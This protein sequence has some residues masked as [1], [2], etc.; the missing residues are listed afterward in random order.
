[1]SPLPHRASYWRTTALAL[2]AAGGC[3]TLIVGLSLAPGPLLV[4]VLIASLVAFPLLLA[5]L[6]GA[7][8]LVCL[9][10]DAREAAG[11][12][13]PLASI[14]IDE[15]RPHWLRFLLGPRL[16]PGDVVRV[17]PRSEIAGTLDEKGT[18][19]GLPFM[20]EM[21]PFCGQTFRVHRR[22]DYINDMRHKTGLR[23]IAGVVTLT[24]VR[25]SGTAHD[26]CEAECQILW[27]DAW[28]ERV[29]S[30]KDAAVPAPFLRQPAP[31]AP[32]QSEHFCQMTALWE[33]SSPLPQRSIGR[34]L[35][36]IRSGNFTL[37]QIAIAALTAAFNTAQE[38]RK[39]TGYPFMPGETTSGGTPLAV[40]DLHPGDFVRIL[41]K[42]QIAATLVGGKNRGLWF[43]RD[44]I[45]FCGKSATVRRQVTRLIHEATGKLVV[46]KT[47]CVALENVVATG[48][49]LALCP[50][51]ELIYWRETWLERVVRGPAQMENKSGEPS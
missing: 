49:F 40:L 31:G 27:K 19:A 33:S 10:R 1:V 44:M 14:A 26:G 32:S 5:L 16:R 36:T 30:R 48:E 18:L 28:L 35:E 43:D 22:V 47:P 37:V 15:R 13:D 29:S 7:G 17:R 6:V 3:T 39:G 23:R 21:S 20:P 8:G 50:Q 45:R 34:Y 12:P 51:H 4:R 41:P 9:W 2:A 25:C 42:D 46:M 38:L 24:A 11:R